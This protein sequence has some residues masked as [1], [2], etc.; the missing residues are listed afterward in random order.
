MTKKSSDI[1]SVYMTELESI[2]KVALIY[3]LRIPFSI[4]KLKAEKGD[5]IT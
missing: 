4:K 5:P 2:C 1:I 3:Y